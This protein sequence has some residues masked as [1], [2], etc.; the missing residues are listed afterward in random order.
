MTYDYT[1]IYERPHTDY[2]TGKIDIIYSV[3]ENNFCLD[4]PHTLLI[5][6]LKNHIKS[7]ID[8]PK[9]QLDKT[10]ECPHN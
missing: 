4:I 3:H 8:T 2:I 10:S 1:R 9:W 6:N 5:V 7:K